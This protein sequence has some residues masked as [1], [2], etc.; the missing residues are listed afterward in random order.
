MIKLQI[1]KTIIEG[2]INPGKYAELQAESLRIEEEI[3]KAQTGTNFVEE[4]NFEDNAS[5]NTKQNRSSSAEC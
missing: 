3:G 5:G 2:V 4:Q 1:L